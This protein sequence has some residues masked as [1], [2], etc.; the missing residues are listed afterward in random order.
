VIIVTFVADP[1]VIIVILV[2]TPFVTFVADPFV[3][4]VTFVAKPFVTF[5]AGMWFIAGPQ[6]KSIVPVLSP[7]CATGLS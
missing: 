5:V 3:I 1:F 7:T 6:K 2:A 4:I